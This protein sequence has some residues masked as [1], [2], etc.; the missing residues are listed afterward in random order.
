MRASN[1]TMNGGGAFFAGFILC[2]FNLV[3]FFTLMFLFLWSVPQKS[4]KTFF[5]YIFSIVFSPIT[6]PEQPIH[7]ENLLLQGLLSLIGLC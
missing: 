4:V 2:V 3:V 6:G 1:T 5:I 7:R